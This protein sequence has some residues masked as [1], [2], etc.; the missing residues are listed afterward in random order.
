MRWLEFFDF[1]HIVKVG[2]WV[3]ISW[4]GSKGG[5]NLM[6][7]QKIPFWK[8]NESKWGLIIFGGLAV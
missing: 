6:S 5:G 1:A 3:C 8:S 2:I 4:G 7:P